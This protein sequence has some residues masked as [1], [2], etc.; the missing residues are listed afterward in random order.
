M[1]SE[2]ENVR[3]NK[4]TLKKADEAEKKAAA[5]V[6]PEKTKPETDEKSK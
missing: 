1:G 4:E 5:E 6:K 3:K 2:K